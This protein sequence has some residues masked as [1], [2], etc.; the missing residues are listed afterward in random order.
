MKDGMY[1]EWIVLMNIL[2]THIEKS[3]FLELLNMKIIS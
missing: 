1:E 2:N 3:Q